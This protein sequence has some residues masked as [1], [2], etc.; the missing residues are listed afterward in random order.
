MPDVSTLVPFLAAIAVIELTPGPN[1]A[2]LALAAA[3]SGLRHGLAT[4]AGVTVGLA[5]FLAASILGLAE[6]ALRWPVGYQAL[7]WAGVIYML[8]LALE[9]WRGA[10]AE[11]TAAEGYRRL[12]LRGLLVNLLNPKAALFYVSIL[13]AFIV[14]AQGGVATQA[15]ALGAIHIAFS[16]VVHLAIVITSARAQDVAARLSSRAVQRAFAV[17]LALTALWVAW[18]T[19]R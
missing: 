19:R 6:L 13:P 4:V 10:E 5:V 3:R 8:W 11:V 12:F 16:V 1:M 14:P 18:S 2:Y 9:T 15:A 7:R 17:A